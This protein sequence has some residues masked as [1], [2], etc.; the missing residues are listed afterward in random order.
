MTSQVTQLVRDSA[1]A[2][3]IG[4]SELTT[5]ATQMAGLTNNSTPYVGAALLFMIVLGPL[6]LASRALE[7]R[8]ALSDS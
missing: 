8:Q 4:Y 1:L 2:F 7:R 3:F 5:R 6:Q